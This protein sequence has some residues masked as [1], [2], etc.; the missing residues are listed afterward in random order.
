MQPPFTVILAHP[1]D[2]ARPSV[3]M[4]LV[5]YAVTRGVGVM[6]VRTHARIPKCYVVIPSAILVFSGELLGYVVLRECRELLI[7]CVLFRLSVEQNIII[8]RT[9]VSGDVPMAVGSLPNKLIQKVIR[10]KI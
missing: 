10:A 9:M 5:R 6:E 8:D 2:V 1:L 3:W 7:P 4:G